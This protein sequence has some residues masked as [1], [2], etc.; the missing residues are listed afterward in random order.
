MIEMFEESLTTLNK[1]LILQEFIGEK[2]WQDL[3][4]FIVWGRIIG[5]MI[6]KWKN[7]DFKSNYSGW[8]EVFSHIITQKEE[9][10][11]LEAANIIGLDIAWIDILFDKDNG[12]KICEVNA[13]PWFEGLEKA[14]WKNIA[15][16]IIQY[17]IQRYNIK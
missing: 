3:R 9:I 12:Y 15:A 17:M 14:T 1:N 7:G 6:R 4:V 2:V 5:C 11:A 10:L 8:G 13:S 16:E